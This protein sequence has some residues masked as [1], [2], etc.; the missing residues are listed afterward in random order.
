MKP[1]QTGEIWCNNTISMSTTKGKD[2]RG[3]AKALFMAGYTY[4]EIGNILRRSKSTISKWGKEDNWTAARVKHSMI[5][6]NS[7]SKLMDI[8]EY[9]IECLHSTMEARKEEGEMLPFENGNFDALQKLYSTIKPDWQKF[10]LYA[11]VMKEFLDFAQ[12][13][14]LN[15]A[16]DMMPIAD[17]FLHMKQK[18][19]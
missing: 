5:E 16:K 6:E 4:E 7:L 17:L 14:N 12:S 19:L 11:S 2:K 15:V 1:G 18:A 8:F 9:Q 10:K 3:P 13:E